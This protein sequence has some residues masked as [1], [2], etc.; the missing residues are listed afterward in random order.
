MH[1]VDCNVRARGR[2]VCL[3]RDNDTVQKF[4]L[5]SGRFLLFLNFEVITDQHG[6]GWDLHCLCG[7]RLP[8]VCSSQNRSC[9]TI[10]CHMIMTDILGSCSTTLFIWWGCERN[11]ILYLWWGMREALNWMHIRRVDAYRAR[12]W[13][14]DERRLI[15]ISLDPSTWWKKY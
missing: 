5:W 12:I 15:P 2:P 1:L 4:K 11:Y 7:V 8:Y 14:H 13:I 10:Q 6:L 3:A 9:M